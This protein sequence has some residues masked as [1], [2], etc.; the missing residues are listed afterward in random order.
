MVKRLTSQNFNRIKFDEPDDIC[1][2]YGDFKILIN[3]KLKYNKQDSVVSV[4]LKRFRYADFKYIVSLVLENSSD[5][6]AD[7]F[8]RSGKAENLVV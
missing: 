3:E 7:F 2:L 6:A 8:L 1:G 5:G 4:R